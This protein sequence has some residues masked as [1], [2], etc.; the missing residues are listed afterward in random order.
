MLRR[1]ALLAIAA[2]RRILVG[3]A[4]VM[5]AAAVFGIPVAKSLSAGGFQDPGAESSRAAQLLTEDFRQG[6][7]QMI[8]TVSSPAGVRSQSARAVALDIVGQLK[9]S[10]HVADVTSAWTVPPSAAAALTSKDGSTG[11]VVVGVTGG[12]NDAQKFA[13]DLS[14]EV[15]HD[16]SDD[17][18]GVTVRSG[19]MAMVYAQI[20][21]QSQ[22]DLLL[23]ESIAIPLSFV[24]LVWV[25]GG[26]IAAALPMVVGGLAIVGAMSVLRLI[27]LSTDVSIFALNLSTALGLALAIDYTLLIISRYRD[28]LGEGVPRDR[29]L[30]RTMSTAG[31][32]VLFSATT[33]ALSMAVMLLFPTYFLKSFAYA[34][35]ATVAFAAA[36]AV[37]V[38]PAAIWLLGD[39][40]DGLDVRRLLRRLTHR[41]E[42]QPRPVEQTF[43]YRSTK[44]V[45]RHALPVGLAVVV[46]LLALGAPFLGVKWGFPDDRVLPTSASSHQVGDQLRDDFVEDSATA[47][48][49][50]VP[51]ARGLSEDALSRYAAEL[52][53]VPDV[54]SVSAPTG[55]FVGGRPVGPPAAATGVADGSAF[56]TVGSAAPLFS[57]ASDAQLDRIHQVSG[58]GGRQVQLAGI[59][60]TNRDSVDAITSRLPWVLGLIA[61]ITFGLLFLLTGSVIL[62]LKAVLL[63]VLSLTAAFGALVWIFQDGHL[64][65]FGTTTTG[66]LVAN[67][68]VLLFCIAFGLS[69]DYEV[70]LVARIREYWLARRPGSDATPSGREAIRAARADNDE[71]VAL[72]LARTGRVITAAAVVMSISFAALI[73]AQVSF[74]R[75]FG[76]GLTLAVLVDATLV[77]M[78]LVPAFMHLVGGWNWWAP[79]PLVRLH[80]RIGISESG[81]A[82]AEPDEDRDQRASTSRG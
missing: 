77:R 82:E 71:A 11:L 44:A 78:V 17:Q 13:K 57:T 75:M 49:V 54:T 4:L 25:F 65:G 55:S 43:W 6:D 70:F 16:R 64:S 19:G 1:I 51:D 18:S 28:E 8:I 42:P 67:M 35:V 76:V 46:L 62:P 26:L 36:A 68:P 12:E 69:M 2:P 3:A 58:P 60:Q 37:I 10:P 63:N 40:L 52:S 47:V 30:V 27:T 73:A 45:M 80:Q 5:V 15:V 29:A 39:R 53:K 66:T 74:M 79:K 34:G 24:V 31:R 22:G 41:H 32:T 23:M 14:D 72:G 48:I 56:L 59:A 21:S 20:T 38:T 33:V 50:V 9:Q 81:P 7:M 61:I